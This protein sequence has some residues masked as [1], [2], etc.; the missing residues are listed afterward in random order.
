M[1]IRHGEPLTGKMVRATSFFFNE[2]KISQS[3][4]VIYVNHLVHEITTDSGESYNGLAS[5]SDILPLCQKNTASLPYC[6][7]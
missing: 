4:I 5:H 2:D 7:A 3:I 6:C 1:S